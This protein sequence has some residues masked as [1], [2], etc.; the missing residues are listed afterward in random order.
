MMI[1]QI[2]INSEQDSKSH[3]TMLK[4]TKSY[5]TERTAVTHTHMMF[6]VPYTT[7]CI[8]GVGIHKTTRT[9]MC[10]VH[11]MQN[12]YSKVSLPECPVKRVRPDFRGKRAPIF[13]WP[14]LQNIKKTPEFRPDFQ[15]R[16]SNIR[17]DLFE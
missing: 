15:C 11:T 9:H 6:I 8:G 12:M 17:P 13:T 3:I 4:S 2:K 16:I 5:F 1:H 10:L 14:E 7:P